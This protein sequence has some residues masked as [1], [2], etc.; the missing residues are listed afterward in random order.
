MLHRDIESLDYPA[1]QSCSANG[2]LNW[3][4]GSGQPDWIATS[5]QQG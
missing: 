5:K 1:I 3:R 4:T 2:W